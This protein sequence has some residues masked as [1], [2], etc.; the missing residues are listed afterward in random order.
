MPQVWEIVE[1]SRSLLW[2]D[3]LPLALA[4][5]VAGVMERRGALTLGS[6]FLSFAGGAFALGAWW[7]LLQALP[8]LRPLARWLGTPGP[9][10]VGGWLRFFAPYLLYGL[11]AW[12]F[13][14]G[15]TLLRCRKR[16]MPFRKG[17]ADSLLLAAF[18][19]CCMVPYV[20]ALATLGL[21]LAGLIYGLGWWLHSGLTPAFVGIG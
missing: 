5:F 9:E 14:S 1:T 10:G 3:A 6:V 16:R 12:P 21:L 4:C 7:A 15:V 13:L 19:G 20:S 11:M 18:T 8:C 17:L 2:A